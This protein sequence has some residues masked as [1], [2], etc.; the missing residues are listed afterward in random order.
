M[1]AASHGRPVQG[2]GHI[3][4]EDTGVW[5]LAEGTSVAFLSRRGRLIA[6]FRRNQ[7][8]SPN[9]GALRV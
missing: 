3:M 8:A 2:T 6:F 5:L 4:E 1:T 9:A 7:P